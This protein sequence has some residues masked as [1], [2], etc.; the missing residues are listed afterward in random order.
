M[1]GWATEIEFRRAEHIHPSKCTN[2][3]FFQ[4][5]H[6]PIRPEFT[7][8]H[9]HH[10]HHLRDHCHRLKFI[11]FSLTYPTICVGQY[12]RQ[13]HSSW[14]ETNIPHTALSSAYRQRLLEL[15]HCYLHITISDACWTIR[16]EESCRSITSHDGCKMSW[17]WGDA[18][19]G[20][21]R[22]ALSLTTSQWANTLIHN[23]SQRSRNGGLTTYTH[24]RHQKIHHRNGRIM[25][26]W[27][28]ECVE[29]TRRWAQCSH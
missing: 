16:D 4:D 12:T 18:E 20:D 13:S 14:L 28:F 29:L 5:T 7:A 15:L 3:A 23:L 9:R 27:A 8:I 26:V 21:S 25:I 1:S 10:P 22:T 11:S 6:E 19:G 24:C 2:S 17:W